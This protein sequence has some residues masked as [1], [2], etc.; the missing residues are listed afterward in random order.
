MNPSRFGAL[1]AIAMAMTGMSRLH[2]QDSAASDSAAIRAADGRKLFEGRGLCFS[3]HGKDG[4]GVLGPTTRLAGRPLVHTK[5]LI[6]DIVALIKSGVDSAHSTSGQVMP[7]SG[8][9][10]LTAR[11]IES[12][13]WYVLALQ[14]RK[15]P[16]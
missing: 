15:K 7:A 2:A 10:R 9:A 6:P 14:E 4:E 12:L 16:D 3:C 11:E 5:L 8:G 13:A 1:L